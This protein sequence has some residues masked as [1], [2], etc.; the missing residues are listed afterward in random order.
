MQN[1]ILRDNL[2][3]KKENC[4]NHCHG[5]R[6]LPKFSE[7]FLSMKTHLRKTFLY[8]NSSLIYAK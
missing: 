8:T 1:D 2:C 5:D 6:F 4:R 7:T 3:E